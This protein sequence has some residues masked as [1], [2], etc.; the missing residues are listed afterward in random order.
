[1]K[2]PAQLIEIEESILAACL[3]F[4]EMRSEALELLTPD[5]FYKPTHAKIF[6]TITGLAK[7]DTVDLLTVSAA[8]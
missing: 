4:P 8:L 1:M 7:N 2:I 3:L 6:K 5:D